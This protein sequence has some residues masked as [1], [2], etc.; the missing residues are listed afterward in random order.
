MNTTWCYCTMKSGGDP[1]RP[2]SGYA[3]KAFGPERSALAVAEEVARGFRDA[4]TRARA[5]LSSAMEP[6]WRRRS[7]TGRTT[8]AI[9]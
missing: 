4:G 1:E 7:S 6:L 9:R 2:Y 3:E 5:R 8:R